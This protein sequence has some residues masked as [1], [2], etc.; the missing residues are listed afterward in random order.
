MAAAWLAAGA[1]ALAACMLGSSFVAARWLLA[2]LDPAPLA[3][4]R[5]AIAGLFLL[6]LGWMLRALGPVRPLDL[7]GI[8]I[9][10][11]LQFGVFHIAF[12]TGLVIIPA[13]RAAIVF[14][15]VTVATMLLAVAT[16]QEPLRATRV[17]GVLAAV[18]GV[19]TALSD[20]ATLGA[21][22]G[23]AWHGDLLILVAVACGSAW[24]AATPP[25]LGRV[26]P[27]A[28][29]VLAMW[30][31]TLFLLPFALRQGL[32]A[33]LPALSSTGLWLLLYLSI[34]TG[35]LSFFLWNW[36]LRHSSPTRVAIFLPLS[37]ITATLL[38]A[39]LLGEPVGLKV[40]VGLGLVALGIWLAHW[41]AP[42]SG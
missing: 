26:T 4:L 22:T 39:A 14:S 29:T 10:G 42:R 37:P 2:E 30:A 19:A 34:P 20:E 3:F 5:F 15:L 36:A 32:A 6:A 24:N 28:V 25:L 23:Q 27:V 31:G 41:P 1:A 8:A 38:G 35:G 16:R 11:V 21:V 12:N 40:G 33:Q 13:S 9:L 17:A 7:L 18:A